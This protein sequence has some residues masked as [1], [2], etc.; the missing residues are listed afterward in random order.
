MGLGLEPFETVLKSALSKIWGLTGY[1]RL[2][3]RFLNN[4]GP[5][6]ARDLVVLTLPAWLKKKDVQHLV[7]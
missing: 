5:L 7:Y 1:A 3:A 4:R 6:Q 2:F